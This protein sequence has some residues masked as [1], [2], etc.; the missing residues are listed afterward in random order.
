MDHGVRA[1]Q[2]RKIQIVLVAASDSRVRKWEPEARPALPWSPDVTVTS[3]TS[4]SPVCG[5]ES[6]TQLNDHLAK[7]S[8]LLVL[9]SVQDTWVSLFSFL[10]PLLAVCTPQ[11]GEFW[12]SGGLLHASESRSKHM[13]K[14]HACWW[15]HVSES[16]MSGWSIAVCVKQ[17]EMQG[18]KNATEAQG[19][20]LKQRMAEQSPPIPRGGRGPTVL[21]LFVVIIIC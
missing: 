16:Q 19:A 12:G 11:S 8:V 13:S 4:C 18:S 15:I 21:S 5:G 1:L 14:A 6:H 9:L 10:L 7:P 2:E 17:A 20:G 3:A